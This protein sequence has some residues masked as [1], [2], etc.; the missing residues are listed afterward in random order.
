MQVFG[1]RTITDPKRTVTT[2]HLLL[3][4]KWNLIPSI[5]TR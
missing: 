3:S 5:C 4:N 2:E 1:S